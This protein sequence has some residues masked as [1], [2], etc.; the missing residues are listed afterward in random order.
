MRLHRSCVALNRAGFVAVL[1]A[2]L[3]AVVAP[4][5]LPGQGSREV[6]Q[7][8]TFLFQPGL[9]DSAVAIYEREIIPAYR[10]NAA[11]L[12]FRAFREAESPE[13]LDLIVVSSFAGMSGMDDSNAALRRQTSGGRSVF[14]WYGALAALSQRHHDQFAE[15]IPELGDA[16]EAAADTSGGLTVMEYVRLTPGNQNAFER[17]LALRVRP[18][19]RQRTLTRWSETGRLLV[20][21]GWDYLRLIGVGSLGAWQTHQQVLRESGVAREV[22]SLV[23]VRKTI[24]VR[25]APRLSVR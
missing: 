10:E 7:F 22:A 18:L 11:M 5:V 8:V 14:Q 20:S 15:M 23:A 21:D 12:R 3:F 13:P 1:L 4:K 19:E 2:V 9:T 6:R 16:A 24:I 17:L 25:N